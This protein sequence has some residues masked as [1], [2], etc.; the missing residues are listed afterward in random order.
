MEATGND[1]NPGRR[2]PFS[3]AFAQAGFNRSDAQVW[4]RA[5]WDDPELAAGW[6]HIERWCAPEQLL[7]LVRD[8]FEAGQVE[9][10]VTG[11]PGLTT[12]QI[13]ARIGRPENRTDDEIDLRERVLENLHLGRS[14]RQEIHQT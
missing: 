3:R 7:T 2:L 10:V 9:E 4:R 8:G 11:S 12:A 13:R 5:G 14:P 1:H 6:R